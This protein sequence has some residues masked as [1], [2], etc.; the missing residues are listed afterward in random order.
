MPLSFITI[1]GGMTTVIGSA[2]NILVADV[3]QRTAKF[4]IEFFSFTPIGLILAGIG[5]IYILV[6]MPFIL[7][8]R[9]TMAEQMNERSGRQFI[10]QIAID[11][12]HPFSRDE[13]CRW[14]VSETQKYDCSDSSTR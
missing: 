9:M 5:L 3:A 8:P 6:V 11:Q 1:L 13:I 7:K 14:H 4:T 10:A 12:N 2:T